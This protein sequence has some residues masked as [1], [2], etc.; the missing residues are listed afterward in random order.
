MGQ[1]C[2]VLT[3]QH[4]EDPSLA[5][6]SRVDS[7]DP[8][9][10]DLMRRSILAT[11]MLELSQSSEGGPSSR[12]RRPVGQSHLLYKNTSKQISGCSM[13]SPAHAT[14]NHSVQV[15]VAVPLVRVTNNSNPRGA[16]SGSHNQKHHPGSKSSS[17]P[18]SW[19]LPSSDEDITFL[20]EAVTTSTRCPTRLLIRQRPVQVLEEGGGTHIYAIRYPDD[21]PQ[22]VVSEQAAPVA[23]PVR[24]E[25]CPP[26][27]PTIQTST[28]ASSPSSTAVLPNKTAPARFLNAATKAKPCQSVSKSSSKL[29]QQQ[30]SNTV[31]GTAP[32]GSS[33]HQ[34]NFTS[35][36]KAPTSTPPAACPVTPSAVSMGTAETVAVVDVFSGSAMAAPP[37]IPGTFPFFRCD[38]TT[39]RNTVLRRSLCSLLVHILQLEN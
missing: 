3:C 37:K 4:V 21:T 15:P 27:K 34:Q 35:T 39:R 22:T 14:D 17:P 26:R 18:P 23:A 16:E 12:K 29:Q 30:T 10:Y 13:G 5:G 8:F 6:M 24:L 38:V 20:G 28:T 9:M 36:R 11:E 19:P 7:P 1:Q 31:T 32:A 2:S 33:S 25:Q